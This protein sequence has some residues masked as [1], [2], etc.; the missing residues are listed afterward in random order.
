MAITHLEAIRN[1]FCADIATATDFGPAAGQCVLKTGATE[2][3]T[4]TLNDPSFTTP[5]V[6][7]VLTLIVA[8]VPEDAAATGNASQ[9]DSMEFQD[10]TGTV[11]FIGDNITAV[12]GGGDLELSKNPIDANDIVQLTSFT[13]TASV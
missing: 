7:G 12:A 1:G 4:I 9:V 13:Y 6:A 5:S 2:V 3:A 10:S 11:V 8:P